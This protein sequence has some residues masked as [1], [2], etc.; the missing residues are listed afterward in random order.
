MIVATEVLGVVG[1]V[2]MHA[3]AVVDTASKAARDAK[4]ADFQLNDPWGLGV[5]IISMLIVMLGLVVI[6]FV[7]KGIGPLID[8]TLAAKGA[9]TASA[10]SH[11]AK[12]VA[13]PVESGDAVAVVIALALHDFEQSMREDDVISLTIQEISRR[14]SPWNDKSFAV[15]RNQMPPRRGC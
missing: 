14:Y 10:S 2:Q 4:I 11:A 5:T 3:A 8:R 15:A 1:A 9:K 12:R 6:Y 13:N 7:F